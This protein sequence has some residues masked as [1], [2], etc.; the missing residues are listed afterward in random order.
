MFFFDHDQAGSRTVDGTRIAAK[1]LP[2]KCGLGNQATL[3]GSREGEFIDCLLPMGIWDR[4][5]K[6]A[7]L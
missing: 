5:W 1:W 4:L 3:R 6:I 2:F 7:H